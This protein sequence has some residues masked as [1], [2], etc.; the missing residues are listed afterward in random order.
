MSVPIVSIFAGG[1]YAEHIRRGVE[2]IKSGGI[3]VLPTE[4]VYGAAGL[5]N[6]PE[7]RDRLAALLREQRGSLYD[8]PGSTRRCIS[9]S[10]QRQ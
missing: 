4:T 3:V 2:L 9:I 1:D 7:S 8:P 5:L 10:W 6:R